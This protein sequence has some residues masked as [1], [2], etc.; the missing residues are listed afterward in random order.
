MNNLLE[1]LN[2][3]LE[4]G[5]EIDPDINPEVVSGKTYKV[6]ISGKVYHIEYV[7]GLTQSNEKIF[8][9]KFK[10]MNNPKLP[11]KSDFKTDQ[12][13]QIA[14]QKSQIGIT[15]TGDAKKVFNAIVSVMVKIIKEELPEYITFQAD[16]ENRKKLYKL[17][18]K[19]VLTKIGRY[20]PIDKH[21]VTDE[22]VG[23]GEF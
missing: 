7:V 19:D 9:F 21:P 12:Q 17:M 13:Y 16:E 23:I 20:Q 8:E 15:G 10:L 5:I 14:L 18:V 6:T 1:Y 11:K 2:Q 3:W 22:M 4:E